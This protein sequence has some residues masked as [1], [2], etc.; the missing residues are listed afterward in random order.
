MENTNFIF[1]IML[2]MGLS[3]L[4]NTLDGLCLALTGKLPLSTLSAYKAEK[5]RERAIARE[6]RRKQREEKKITR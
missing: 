2:F 1:Y 5:R 3:T 6:E 4:M